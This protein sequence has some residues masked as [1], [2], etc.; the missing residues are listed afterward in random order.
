MMVVPP[1]SAIIPSCDSPPEADRGEKTA[2]KPIPVIKTSGATR[3]L[4]GNFTSPGM[5]CPFQRSFAGGKEPQGHRSSLPTEVILSVPQGEGFF[6]A[7]GEESPVTLV[8]NLREVG[9]SRGRVSD[10]LEA[11]LWRRREWGFR[12]WR[13]HRQVNGGRDV[14]NIIPREAGRSVPEGHPLFNAAP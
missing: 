7:S 9:N 2:A 6:S 13:P 4:L 10:E 11:I 14:L 12:R 1:P 5:F 8:A 3:Y